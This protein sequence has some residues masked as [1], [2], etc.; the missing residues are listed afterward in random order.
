MTDRVPTNHATVTLIR[1]DFDNDLIELGCNVH[2]LD[3][4]S[5]KANNVG[6]TIDTANG[7]TG[8]CFGN[9]GSAT[10]LVKVITRT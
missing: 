9:D 3:G 1:E 8:Q 5:N 4:A 6:R 10:N 2:P 7:I